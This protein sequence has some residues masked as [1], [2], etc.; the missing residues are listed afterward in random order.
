MHSPGQGIRGAQARRAH[1]GDQRQVHG[2]AEISS[3]F[4]HTYGLR[5]GSL[6]QVH[7]ASCGTCL[8][9]AIG[10]LGRFR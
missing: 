4:E 3:A 2:F 7:I 6:A 1:T 10:V 9:Q 5:Q 8:S